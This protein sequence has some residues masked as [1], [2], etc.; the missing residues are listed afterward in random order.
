MTSVSCRGYIGIDPGA[1]G[2]VALVHDDT[3]QVFDMP[4]VRV[5]IGRSEKQRIADAD[6][7]DL[8]R[9][10]ALYRPQRAV[11]EAVNGIMGQSA[12][13]SFAFGDAVGATRMAFVAAG[14][15]ITTVA[16]VVW[17]RALNVRDGKD[18]SRAMA[19]QLFPAF[20]HLFSRVKDDG[21]AEAV[22]IAEY[23]RR[24]G[25]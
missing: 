12:S 23:A 19:A 7:L 8:A 24:V 17:K 18:G 13:A 16:P 3:V 6:L 10:L 11:I 2:A 15:S 21:R 25:L 9:D 22:L 1:T 14:H 4:T 20:A 5:K